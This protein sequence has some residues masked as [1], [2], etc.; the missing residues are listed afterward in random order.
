MRVSLRLVRHA[1]ARHPQLNRQAGT[2]YLAVDV[3]RRHVSPDE[4]IKARIRRSVSGREDARI[5]YLH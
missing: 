5:L 3:W 2:Y 4:G 1:Y